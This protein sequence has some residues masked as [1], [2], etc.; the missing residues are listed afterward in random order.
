MKTLTVKDNIHGRHTEINAKSTY[1][2]ASGEWIAEVTDNEMRR[3]CYELY[4]GL[5]ECKLEDL[6]IEAAQDDD[7]KEYTIVTNQPGE[8]Q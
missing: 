3:A 1:Q 8:G 7:G 2:T 4:R 6:R 5:K